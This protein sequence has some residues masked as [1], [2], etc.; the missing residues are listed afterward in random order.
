MSDLQTAQITITR[1]LTDTGQDEVAI[2]DDTTSL[3]EA[4]GLLE[5]A[6]DSIIRGCMD[7]DTEDDE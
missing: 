6:K 2:T 4:L 1:T 7:P 3:V 5:F